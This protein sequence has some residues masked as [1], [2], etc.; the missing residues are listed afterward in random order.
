MSAPQ[1]TLRFMAI[2]STI[3]LFSNCSNSDDNNT[4]STKYWK[5][6][7]PGYGF[8]TAIRSDGTLWAWGYNELGNLGNGTTVDS[9]IPIQI[10]TDSDWESIASGGGYS[11]G[12]KSNGTLWAW[13]R[14]IL[15]LATYT[16]SIG[17]IRQP[18]QV[19]TA[20]NWKFISAGDASGLG[21][22]DDGTLW[23]WGTSNG[24]INEIDGQTQPTRLGTDTNWKSASI[25][26]DHIVGIKTNSTLWS[27]GY[28]YYGAVGNN[29]F[30]DGSATIVSYKAQ[31]YTQATNW[32]KAFAGKHT[33]SLKN[34]GTL[35]AW[36]NN[37]F[38]E[39]GIGNLT[40]KN[41][42]TQVGTES[43]WKTFYASYIL[44]LAIKN[45]GTLWGWGEN[46]IGQIGD[47][48]NTNKSSPVKIG[49]DS[50]W[51]NVI[52]S[53]DHSFA[54]KAD[55]TLWAWGHNA[56]GQLGNGTNVDSNVPVLIACP[57]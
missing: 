20:N 31:E 8:T 32:T 1:K 46:A 56:Y 53:N 40:D 25:D 7:S 36:G 5:T 34:D 45:D 23:V 26:T 12:I 42:P 30:G 50:D 16:G 28:N 29:V 18:F 15:G 35:W 41:I 10:G 43:N 11:C 13:G 6:V 9:N 3:L 22:K 2:L 57:Q 19:G 17:P 49:V 51:E 14:P 38:G 52:F 55:K 4:L 21:I 44:T 54:Q 33:V 39:L 37:A 48:T 27:W 47:G 24:F